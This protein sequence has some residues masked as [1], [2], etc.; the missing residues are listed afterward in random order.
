M[1]LHKSHYK[2]L[3]KPSPEVCNS[4]C[5]GDISRA[6]TLH[7]HSLWGVPTAGTVK[8]MGQHLQPCQA[9]LQEHISV[10]MYRL[11]ESRDGKGFGHPVLLVGKDMALA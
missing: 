8:K 2:V 11:R 1:L 7:G 5:R 3:A 10:G 9:A 6:I 4:S